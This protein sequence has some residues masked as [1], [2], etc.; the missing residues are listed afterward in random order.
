MLVFFL[1]VALLYPLGCLYNFS[2]ANKLETSSTGSFIQLN[3]QHV[4][5]FVVVSL[6]SGQVWTA[7]VLD[8]SCG[9]SLVIRV[10]RLSQRCD[11]GSS[12][13]I[14]GCSSFFCH[15][16]DLTPGWKEASTQVSMQGSWKATIFLT[17]PLWFTSLGAQKSLYYE[18]G[19][20]NF[21]LWGPRGIHSPA[22]LI[23]V[24]KWSQT[25]TQRPPN[26]EDA[27]QCPSLHSVPTLPVVPFEFHNTNT[28]WALTE[29]W[30]CA[31]ECLIS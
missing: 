4:E 7:N 29:Y 18:M 5:R 1:C 13:G 20:F 10:Q 19:S 12:P 26:C 28:Y 8:R 27:K 3:I 30:A 2:G 11:L 16:D 6:F 22:I 23:I 14:K 24:P 25:F 15:L 31:R 17:Q 21:Y 9:F